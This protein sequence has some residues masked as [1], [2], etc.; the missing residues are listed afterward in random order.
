MA[1]VFSGFLCGYGLALVA[2]PAIAIAL[3]R[4]RVSS[5]LVKQIMPEGTSLIA[6]SLIIHTFAIFTLTAVGLLLGIML[7]GL[8]DRSPDG[9]LGSPNQAFTAFILITT[10]I[11]VLPM[12]I[13]LPKWRRAL[14]AGGLI[15]VATFGWLMPYLSLIGPSS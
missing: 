7:A 4:A 14:L 6:V 8:D 11:A 5:A 12:A 10:A 9:G 2:T 3:V 13:V 1:A 15:F